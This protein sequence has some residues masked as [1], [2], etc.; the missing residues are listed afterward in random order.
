MSTAIFQKLSVLVL[1][2]PLDTDIEAYLEHRHQTAGWA[3]IA[4]DVNG[5]LN[6]QAQLHGGANLVQ[7]MAWNGLGLELSDEQAAEIYALVSSGA[8]TWAQLLT[9]AITGLSGSLAETLDNRGAAAEAFTAAIVEQ[10][11]EDLDGNANINGAAHNLLLAIGADDLT[12]A[13]GMEALLALVDNLSAAG[14]GGLASDGR[15]RGATVYVD[16]NGNGMFDEGESVGTTAADG[17]FS[18][19]AG[20]T[21]GTLIMTGGTDILAVAPFGTIMMAPA[22]SSVITALTSLAQA[23]IDIGAAANPL[24]GG[25]AATAAL[26][27]APVNVLV[28]DPVAVLAD[29]EATP[30]AYLEALAIETVSIQLMNLVAHITAA[31]VAEAGMDTDEAGQAAWEAVAQAAV[32]GTLDLTDAESLTA[33]IGDAAGGELS[34][35]M[36]SDLVAVIDFQNDA[37]GETDTIVE[38]AQVAAA[39][40]DAVEDVA[41]AIDGSDEDM[42]AWVIEYTGQESIDGAEPGFLLPG[43]LVGEGE[44]D[45][46][47]TGADGTVVVHEDVPYS[48]SAADFG[49]SDINTGDSLAAVRIDTLPTQGSLWFNGS[50]VAAG[51]VIDADTIGQLAYLTDP[52]EH[53]AAYAS[54]EFSVQDQSGL[55]DTEPRTLTIDVSQPPVGEIFL[56]GRPVVGEMIHAVVELDDP[57]G[58]GEISWTWYVDGV[59]LEGETTYKLVIT[60]AMIDKPIYAVA[61]YVDGGGWTEVVHSDVKIG[62]FDPNAEPVG[63]VSITGVPTEDQV[64]TA[65][66]DLTDEDGMGEISYQWFADGVAIAGE[67]GTTLTLSQDEVGKEITVRARYTDGGGTVESVMSEPT[68]EVANV[69]DAPTLGAVNDFATNE[70]VPLVI[71]YDQYLAAADEFDEDGDT[72]SFQINGIGDGGTLEV[73]YNGGE[74]WAPVTVGEDSLEEG[75]AVRW[76]P[77]AE[78]SGADIAAFSAQAYD[79]VVYSGTDVW[80]EVDVTAVND[81]PTLSGQANISGTE[82]TNVTVTFTELAG[83]LTEA[84][85]E[86]DAVSFIVKTLSDDGLL[87]MSIGEDTW[88]NVA[89]GD[90]IDTGDVMR[91]IPDANISGTVTAFTVAAFDG[92]LESTSTAPV[93]IYLN[94]VNDP[95]TLT[96]VNTLTGASE[97]DP[98]VITYD[99][100]AAAADEADVD[101]TTPSFRVGTVTTGTL[102]FWDGDSWE[103]VVANTTV[104]GTSGSL[105]WTPA[106]EANGTLSAFTV[107]AWDGTAASSNVQVS[108]S[109]GAGVAPVLSDV[110]L[111]LTTVQETVGSAPSAPTSTTGAT[112]VS[113]LVAEG[114]SPNNVSDSDDNLFGIA[115]TAFNASGS[116]RMWYS[117]NGGTVWTEVTSP[118]AAAAI[119]L[120][121][122]DWVMFKPNGGVAAQTINSVFTFKAW[123]LSGGTSGATANT[124]AGDSWSTATDTV[125]IVITAAPGQTPVLTEGTDTF[126]G[127]S[128]NDSLNAL[129]GDDS[130]HGGAGDDT[131]DGGTGS[132][133]LDGGSGNDNITAGE[134][135][136][137]VLGGTGNDTLTGNQ[138]GDTLR[139]GAG[140][141]VISGEQSADEIRF[142]ATSSANGVD[143]LTVTISNNQDILSFPTTLLTATNLGVEAGGGAFSGNITAITSATTTNLDLSGNIAVY[144][145]GTVST[146]VDDPSEIAAL[147]QTD[148]IELAAGAS[149]VLVTGGTTVATGYVWYIVNDGTTAVATGEVTLVGTLNFGTDDIADMHA[150]NFARYTP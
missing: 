141:D 106:A 90:E 87:Q 71:T 14:V 108:V 5:Y 72:L 125:S 133:T 107:A 43:V 53:G 63:T 30:E 58:M 65:S 135:G 45:I 148:D 138:A 57:D 80:L 79:G 15:I 140:N 46:P 42:D 104:I 117:T 113:S 142:E 82:D 116:G 86:G 26:G 111:S 19:P 123:D 126:F 10:D 132:D 115:I 4:A 131:I 66:N 52:D 28:Y 61:T 134:Q 130:I 137:F 143:A 129:G 7:D 64:L 39:M 114:T 2:I 38:L 6:N 127:G 85:I 92:A 94:P 95:P 128:G 69:N 144:S 60:E 59:L 139:G 76:T 51:Q 83:D 119:L 122:D 74:D 146:G 37:A 77:D 54:F 73:S 22:G 78:S 50:A 100:L 34:E 25:S 55:F 18:V 44:P 149:A 36:I 20:E 145:G 17:S 47:P 98:F 16:A 12:F 62:R 29:D 96:T 27:I 32:A 9:K 8:I 48:F 24:A 21:T 11:K 102:A 101:G 105:R 121:N 23:L 103:P 150:T 147:F 99:T 56:F 112:Q 31:L 110:A 75:G 1:G 118:T 124:T 3:G 89:V 93:Y 81:A 70:D 68:E 40:G 91:W 97:D 49:F 109:V 120:D 35:D 84:D 13:Q 67:T 88:A 136:D 41:A 33:I